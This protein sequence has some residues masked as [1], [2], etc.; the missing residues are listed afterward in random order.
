M[1]ALCR[2][3]DY[4]YFDIYVHIDKRS[5]IT[6]FD[7]DN[8]GLKYSKLYVLKDRIKVRWGDVSQVDAA[9][10]MYEQALN[11][12]DYCRYVTIS[13]LDFPIKSNEK[14]YETLIKSDIEFIKGNPITKKDEHKVRNYYF[15]KLGKFGS[16][17]SRGL[18]LL[19]IKRKDKLFIDGKEVSIYFAPSWH[20]LSGEFVKYMFDVLKRNNVRDYF[21]F[22]Y[23]SDEL[24]IPTI[25]F[26]N[27]K[28]KS[29][30]IAC[31]FPENTHYNEKTALHY[32][33]YEPVIEVYD[34]NSFDKIINSDKMFVRKVT[35]DKSEKLI[36]L[37]LERTHGGNQNRL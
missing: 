25:L 35:S 15:W 29:R 18:K 20:G 21:R 27:D 17:I 12:Y 32:L 13:G 14:I 23:A 4:E 8:Y 16:L 31:D 34:E 22:A 6:L 30:A 24:M 37:I 26:N 28:F 5:D 36:N 3:L 9:L 2:A 19:K 11:T 1:K 10:K 33:N 7:T